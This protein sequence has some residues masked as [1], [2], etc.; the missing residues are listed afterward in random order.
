[1]ASVNFK[2]VH[3]LPSVKDIVH[4]LYQTINL[5]LLVEKELIIRGSDSEVE[6]ALLEDKKLVEL[7]TQAKNEAFVVG[8]IFLGEIGMLRNDLNAAFVN[9]GVR[10]DAF[11]HYT[12]LGPQV[13]SL[14]KF[15]KVVQKKQYNS[16]NLDNFQLEPDNRKD[17]IINKVFHRKQPILVQILKEPISTKGPRLTCEIT[18]PGRFLVLTPFANIIAISKKISNPEERKR[19]KVLAES[20]KPKNFG[21]ILRTAAEGKK[22]AELYEEISGLMAK[23]TGIYNEL[24]LNLKPRKLLSEIDKTSTIFRDLLND[25]F[26]KVVIN[27]NL[28]YENVK[29]Y[30]KGIAPDKVK[31]VKKYRGQKP[32]FE[33]YG[34]NR[35]IKSSFGKTSTMKSGA[36]L[37]IESTEAM[38]VIDVNS[39][40]KSSKQN[41]E[42][43][44]LNV[45]LEAA[46]D[47]ARQLRLRDI[48]GLIIIDFIDMRNN[49]HKSRLFTSMKNY[50]KLDRAQHTILP[51]SK[52]GLMQ[53]TRQRL[54]PA[55]KIE[56][57][58]S[59]PVCNGTNI[60]ENSM[61]FLD[62]LERAITL[63]LQNRPTAKIN[64]T[65]HPYIYSHLKRGF[66]NSKQWQWYRQYKKWIKIKQNP[67]FHL[68]QFKFFDGFKDEIRLN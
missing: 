15:T 56:T 57:E 52:F 12:D 33:S 68:K 19:L 29:D 66:L 51:L 44:A 28:I 60:V 39:G 25:D 59:C 42:S 20:I 11:L 61:L 64:L 45:N 3:P 1:M 4:W 18:L 5:G 41:Q 10:K 50:M 40:P 6:I 34:V 27:D 9:V 35:Q 37:V 21:L 14:Q 16:A 62:E 13:K 26:N 22:V 58:E 23:W 17:G 7:H 47:I 36:Y 67:E 53:I 49:E 48:G 2:S 38:H 43:A 31:I 46:E 30:V 54:K 65:V 63:I 32:I 24:Q 8:D 55:L